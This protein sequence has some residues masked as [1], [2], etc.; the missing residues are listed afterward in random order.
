MEQN[1]NKTANATKLLTEEEIKAFAIAWYDAL[2]IHAPVEECYRMLADNDLKMDFPEGLIRD[3]AGFGR[4]YK[5]W[6]SLYFDESHI[7]QS[8]TST[9]DGV[10]AECEVIVGWQASWFPAP[11]P[12]SKRTSLNAV[13]HWKVRRS[14]KNPYSVEMVEYRVIR[15]EYAPGFAQL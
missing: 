14:S 7:I 2:D 9:I 10:E 6:I 8:V 13:Q 15:F 11:A 5:Q 1:M 12:K 3:L 4:L